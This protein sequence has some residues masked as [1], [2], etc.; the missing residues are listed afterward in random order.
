MGLLNMPAI[1]FGI[2]QDR[3]STNC[4]SAWLSAKCNSLLDPSES[5]GPKN[6]T[7]RG[8]L[9]PRLLVHVAV[10]LITSHGL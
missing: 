1:Y 6:G 10:H 9:W 4:C 5:Q 8:R 2:R 7:W 3:V